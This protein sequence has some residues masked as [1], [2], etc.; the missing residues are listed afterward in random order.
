MLD[1]SV[2]V[3]PTLSGVARFEYEF[4]EN[5]SSSIWTCAGTGSTCF[6]NS[7][8]VSCK[9]WKPQASA[10]CRALQACVVIHKRVQPK[11]SRG[12]MPQGIEPIGTGLA[13]AP[14]KACLEPLVSKEAKNELAEVGRS[15][16]V[17]DRV[18]K[19]ASFIV[20]AIISNMVTVPNMRRRSWPIG[21][22]SNPPDTGRRSAHGSGIITVIIWVTL[23]PR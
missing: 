10:R 4:F 18:R 1:D 12:I 2:Y 5:R 22:D 9:G 23:P 16:T 7:T 14:G 13:Y 19:S 17:V 21:S 3:P 15:A 6:R 20:C 8:G 11:T